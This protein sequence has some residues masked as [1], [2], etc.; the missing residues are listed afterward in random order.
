MPH[1]QI[2][3]GNKII[4]FAAIAARARRPVLETDGEKGTILL[5]TGI[6]YERMDDGDEHEAEDTRSERRDDIWA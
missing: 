2:S 6:R 5:F 1:P 4:A 3:A